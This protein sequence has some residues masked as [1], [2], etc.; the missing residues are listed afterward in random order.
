MPISVELKY[1]YFLSWPGRIK[2]AEVVR[3]NKPMT[4]SQLSF[5]TLVPLGIL[6]EGLVLNLK[7]L[8]NYFCKVLNQCLG[9]NQ[10]LGEAYFCPFFT[11]FCAKNVQKQVKN[12]IFK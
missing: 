2:L 6:L 8:D 12:A 7:G 4:T 10:R 5:P 3:P 1:E 9:A 11:C